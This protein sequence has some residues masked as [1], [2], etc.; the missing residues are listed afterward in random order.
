[1]VLLNKV[2][3]ALSVFY[4]LFVSLFAATGKTNSSVETT[5]V[6]VTRASETLDLATLGAYV[7]DDRAKLNLV[8]EAFRKEHI[9]TDDGFFDP[10]I[11][12]ADACPDNPETQRAF[13]NH[14]K[15]K[16][17]QVEVTSFIRCGECNATGKMSV[18]SGDSL[19]SRFF[20]HTP[21][22]G[23]G[24]IE[25]RITYTLVYNGTPPARLPTKNQR[26]F[27]A[28][29]KRVAKGDIDAEYELGQYLDTG[30]GT[31]KDPKKAME[32]FTR[33]LMRKD[34]RGAFGLGGQYER[35]T[36]ITQNNFPVSVALYMLGQSLGGGS[37][38]LENIYRIAPPRDVVLGSWYGRILVKEFKAGKVDSTQLS[39]M[40]LRQLAESSSQNK[41]VKSVAKDGEQELQD[42]MALLAGGEN[43]KSNY[44]VAYKKFIQ[45][46]S[47]GQADALYCLGVFYDNG[48]AVSKN[49]STAYVFYKLAATIAGEDY[50]KIAEKTLA[51]ACR[52]DENE[53]AYKL[54][55][56]QIGSGKTN[57][58]KFALVTGLK[59]VEEIVASNP[60]PN[61]PVANT[62][63]VTF[64]EFSNA[65]LKVVGNGS[66]LIFNN[67][68]YFFTNKH[69]VKD[70]KAFS[71]QI[72]GVG[73][74]RRASLV[75]TDPVYDLAILKI[76]NWKG[77]SE[78]GQPTPSLLL[79]ASNATVG[80]KV[81]TVG[82]PDTDLLNQSPKYTSGDLGSLNG[83]DWKA[84]SMLVTCPIQPGNSGGALV[85]ENG[86]VA[87]TISSSVSPR[88]FAMTNKGALPQGLNLAIRIEYLRQLAERNSVKIPA[89][90]LRVVD[91][92][93]VITANSVIVF[94]WQ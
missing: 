23:S 64:S 81:F 72:A 93:K 41:S 84:G 34:P 91:P 1:M 10:A 90:A 29:E 60:E 11:N 12:G 2:T 36:T 13:L 50:M 38:N 35:G 46:A 27:T 87:G 49:K 53:A 25:A 45:A 67:E 80:S 88:Y 85:L 17:T 56:D 40:G 54:A 3:R 78:T 69:V 82:Y 74:M 70:G 18:Y 9:F 32:M 42:G 73:E 4:F 52:T 79:S 7:Q 75:A 65:N 19:S 71:V 16:S 8:W 86:Q 62:T 39:A 33:C 5:Y 77:I 61:A 15:T 48:L 21:C 43:Q 51:P 20:Y 14:V 37:A 30:R 89:P 63:Q 57:N 55:F 22:N 28:L 24:K 31:T 94:K 59:D 58:D 92:A 44:L 76:E 47:Y 83:P 68:G 6:P 26:D 66:G